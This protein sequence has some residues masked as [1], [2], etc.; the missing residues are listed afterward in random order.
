MYSV[1]FTDRSF[2]KVEDE[3]AHK[4]MQAQNSTTK[5]EYVQIGNNQYKLASINKIEEIKQPVYETKQLTTGDRCHGEK[6]IHAV[7]YE[8][9]KKKLK[10]GQHPDFKDFRQKTYDWLYEKY[11]EKKWCD[12]YK[13]TCACEQTRM[14]ERVKEIIPGAV[15]LRG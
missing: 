2:I 12:H 7:I 5:T 4:I 1:H 15:E 3:Q 13:D 14:V 10:A 6:S 11:P 8:A 9:Y